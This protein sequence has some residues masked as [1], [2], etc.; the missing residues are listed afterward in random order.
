MNIYIDIDEEAVI[1]SEFKLEDGRDYRDAIKDA[2][3]AAHKEVKCPYDIEV[4]VMITDNNGIHEINRDTREI[5]RPT[6]VLSFPTLEYDEPGDFSHISPKN[7]Y[8]FN[9]ETNELIFGDIV[10]S[11]DKIVEQAKEYGHSILRELSFLVIHSMLHLSGYDHMEEDGD[12]MEKLGEKILE[13]MNI[14]RD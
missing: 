2:I 7:V 13:D 14:T 9:P 8:L 3:Y 1:N 12:T 6:D 4:N 10:L 11:S 5:D